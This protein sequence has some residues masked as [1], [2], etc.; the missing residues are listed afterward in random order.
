VE[1]DKRTVTDALRRRG[2][3]DRAQA[4]ECSLPRHI[5]TERDANLLHRFDVEVAALT[6][7]A[8]REGA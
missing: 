7:Q 4:A 5:D 2:D 3:H 1:L 6:R 8:G